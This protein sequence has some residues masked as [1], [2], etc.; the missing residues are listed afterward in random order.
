[1]EK[2]TGDRLEMLAHASKHATPEF[3]FEASMGIYVFK[4]APRASPPSYLRKYMCLSLPLCNEGSAADR[5][6]VPGRLLIAAGSGKHRSKIGLM[7]GLTSPLARRR[8]ALVAL[9]AGQEGHYG[10]DSGPDTH[11]GHDVIPHALR[12]GY[13]VVAHHFSGYFRVRARCPHARLCLL[14]CCCCKVQKSREDDAEVI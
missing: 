2:P 12:D 7:I 11:F 5:V 10:K 6:A 3:P 8:N 4:C 13:R 1:M 9:L 14:G